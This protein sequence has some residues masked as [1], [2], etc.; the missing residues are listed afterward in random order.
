LTKIR[1]ILSRELWA[2][3]LNNTLFSGKFGFYTGN[4]SKGRVL[5]TR[6]DLKKRGKVDDFLTESNSKIDDIESEKDIKH[7]YYWIEH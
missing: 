5:E 2:L 1:K 6:R 3:S 4:F 7:Q